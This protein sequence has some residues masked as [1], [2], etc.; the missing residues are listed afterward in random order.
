VT[1]L[2]RTSVVEDYLKQLYKLSQNVSLVSMNQMT[3]AMGVSPGTA[4]A[5]V[6][7]LEKLEYVKYTPFKGCQLTPKGE[8]EGALIL[9]KHRILE[10]F[11]ADKL[12]LPLHQVHQEA[13]RLEHGLSLLVLDALDHYLNHPDSDPHG[14]EI[15]LFTKGPWDT[16]T[17]DQG[18]PGQPYHIEQLE[19][20]DDALKERLHSMGLSSGSQVLLEA[21]DPLLEQGVLLN[22]RG[23]KI[24]LGYSVLEKII[25]GRIL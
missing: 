17:L 19:T 18:E 8:Q 23:E 10:V 16:L 15:P 5:M 21:R 14:H 2:S 4:T 11:L 6:K 1:K 22:S 7:K 20:V 3:E 9:R 24:I 13:E 12:K 25:C